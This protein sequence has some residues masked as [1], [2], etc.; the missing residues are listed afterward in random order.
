M[1]IRSEMPVRSLALVAIVLAA[2]VMR[3][4]P[5]AAESAA[6]RPVLRFALI[7]TQ[8]RQETEAKWTPVL[9]ALGRHPWVPVADRP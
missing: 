4:E 1:T 6:A 5:A 3:P 8:S 7:S 2:V 9:N